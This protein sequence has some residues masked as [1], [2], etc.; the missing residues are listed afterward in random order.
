[1]LLTYNVVYLKSVIKITFQYS[2]IL[3]AKSSS[4]SDQIPE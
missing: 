2:T 1:M 4:L 3:T